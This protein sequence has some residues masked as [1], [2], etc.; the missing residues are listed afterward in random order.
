M[1]ILALYWLF[2]IT[3]SIASIYELLFP[4]MRLQPSPINSKY[5][6]IFTFFII[7]IL[8]APLVFLSCIVPSMGERFRQALDVG[9][10]PD[11]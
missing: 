4:V 3:T 6:I 8:I 11:A 10:F 2:A 9:L 7:N 5:L 1:T